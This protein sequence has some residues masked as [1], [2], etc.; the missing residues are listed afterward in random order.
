MIAKKRKIFI[1]AV[2]IAVHIVA[3]FLFGGVYKAIASFEKSDLSLAYRQNEVAKPEALSFFPLNPES[4]FTTTFKSPVD[5]LGSISLYFKRLPKESDK[6]PNGHFNIKITVFDQTNN[7][8]IVNNEYEVFHNKATVLEYPFGFPIQ[9]NSRGNKYKITI[10]P[11][12]KNGIDPSFMG[13]ALQKNEPVV[14]ALYHIPA[15]LANDYLHQ[16]VN[17]VALKIYKNISSYIILVFVFIYNLF[18]IDKFIKHKKYSTLKN[19]FLTNT[20]LLAT[21]GIL[22]TNRPN[23]L[24]SRFLNTANVYILFSCLFFGLIF[25]IYNES[26]FFKTKG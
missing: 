7:K 2:L 9:K 10:R 1:T 3:F 25:I 24:V 11:L 20:F 17:L 26:N 19:G 21:H 13:L 15:D 14:V 4:G 5:F 8:Y 12:N 16:T 6:K 23:L 18:L 22:Y